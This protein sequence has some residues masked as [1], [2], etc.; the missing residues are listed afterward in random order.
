MIE[1]KFLKQSIL[2]HALLLIILSV[3][4]IF[5]RSPHDNK[6]LVEFRVIEAANKVLKKTSVMPLKSAPIKSTGSKKKEFNNKK[7]ASKRKVFG[8][9]KKR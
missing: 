7:I 9:S 2:Y 1:D 4:V 6:N 3:L 8:V 5:F